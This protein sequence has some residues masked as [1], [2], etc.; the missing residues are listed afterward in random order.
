M[1]ISFPRIWCIIIIF[2]LCLIDAFHLSLPNLRYT[3]ELSRLQM[4]SPKPKG[5]LNTPEG[6]SKIFE[7]A[8]IL[9]QNI[10]MIMAIP[11]HGVE[12][13][14]IYEFKRQLPEGTRSGMVKNTI[15]RRTVENMTEFCAITDKQAAH[16]IMYLFIN[17]YEHGK[18]TFDL[19]NK[20][21]EEVDRLD[22]KY[23]ITFAA[24]EGHLY[25]GPMIKEMLYGPSRKESITKLIKILKQGPT[26]LV[27]TLRK[28]PNKL[29]ITLNA[30]RMKMEKEQQAGRPGTTVAELL[31][32][33]QK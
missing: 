5:G 6:K 15:L 19:Y 26:R 2:S 13:S 1:M 30:I 7:R 31:L 10:T 29:G 24:L 18:I 4:A 11:V 16:E 23:D 9:V 22:P 17:Q 25:Q 28:I 3:H 12:N 14:E 33:D 32:H 20:W 21:R 27:Q 8:A